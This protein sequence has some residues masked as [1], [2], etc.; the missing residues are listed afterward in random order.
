MRGR[1]PVFKKHVPDGM[2]L[3]R[4]WADIP[5]LSREDIAVR[6]ESLVP[7]DADLSRMIVYDTSGTTGHAM[8]VPHHPA[9]V[10][11]SE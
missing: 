10:A 6:V 1:V 3:E 2:D 9:A 11:K 7:L 4:D 5:T 8:V